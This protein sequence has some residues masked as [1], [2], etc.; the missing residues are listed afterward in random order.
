MI[1]KSNS[2]LESKLQAVTIQLKYTVGLAEKKANLS[3]SLFED[4]FVS[5]CKEPQHMI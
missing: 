5:D 4:K 2:I 3:F 1:K